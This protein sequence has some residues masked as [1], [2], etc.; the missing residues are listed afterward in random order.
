MGCRARRVKV[1]RFSVGRPRRGGGARLSGQSQARCLL[2]A[3]LLNAGL[4]K[5]PALDFVVMDAQQVERPSDVILFSDALRSMPLYLCADSAWYIQPF[6][7]ARKRPAQAVQGQFQAR[8]GA[9]VAV[10]NARLFDMA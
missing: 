4:F 1:S 2:F 5:N 10:G 8:S 7:Q 3:R 6:A 9:R